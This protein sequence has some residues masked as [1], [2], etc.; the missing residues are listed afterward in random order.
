MGEARR[1]AKEREDRVRMAM[2]RDGVKDRFEPVVVGMDK[3][4]RNI[5]GSAAEFMAVMSG[6]RKRIGR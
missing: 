6:P 3:K 1:R 4:M 2:E 5:F